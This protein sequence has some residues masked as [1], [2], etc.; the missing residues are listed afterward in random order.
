MSSHDW[1]I[2]NGLVLFFGDGL[3]IDHR[4]ELF[5]GDEA[6]LQYEDHY[7]DV[8]YV[9]YDDEDDAYV[10]NVIG[11]E[12]TNTDDPISIDIHRGDEVWFEFEQVFQ[13]TRA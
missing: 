10:G 3:P 4:E 13:I 5:D 8:R 7:I 2:N 6:R 9:D 11:V 1:D 12:P